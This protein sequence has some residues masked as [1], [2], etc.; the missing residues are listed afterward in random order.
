MKITINIIILFLALTTFAQEKTDKLPTY[1]GLQVRSVFPTNFIGSKTTSMSESG[2]ET[3]I[4]QRLGFGLGGVVRANVTKLIA[5][6]TGIN[7]TQ[8][9]FDISVAIP[10]SNVHAK[11]SMTFVEYDVPINALYTSS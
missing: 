6:E 8:R 2:F 4:T 5:I 10:D 9:H 3:S 7:F 1:F 11:D